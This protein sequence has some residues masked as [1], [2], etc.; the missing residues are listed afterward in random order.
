MTRNGWLDEH[1]DVLFRFAMARL[2]NLE[3]AE[4]M[5]QETFFAALKSAKSYSGRSSE[6][7]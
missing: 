4:D 2:R 5:V 3:A 7:T 1:G 6:R